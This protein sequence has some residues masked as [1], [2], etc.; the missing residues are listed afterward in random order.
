MR[1]FPTLKWPTL[2]HLFPSP[3]LKDE[4]G[5]RYGM[6]TVIAPS[7]VYGGSAG[8]SWLCVCDCGSAPKPISGSG[9]RAG[10]IKSCG[11]HRRGKTPTHGMSKHPAYRSYAAAKSRCNPARGL[12]NYGGRGIQFQLPPFPDFWAVMGP[13]WFEG[14]TLDRR[15][16]DGH[17]HLDNVRWATMKEQ[18][19]NRRPIRPRKPK[20]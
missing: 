14:G 11:C 12:P 6:L 15:D 4:T 3:H 1:A 13:T 18:A 19:G 2:A 7:A 9:L 20:P 17:Y 16:N 8:R 10:N 5:N